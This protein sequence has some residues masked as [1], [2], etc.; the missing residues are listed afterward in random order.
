MG[1]SSLI[2]AAVVQITMSC[3][4][5]KKIENVSS[6]THPQDPFIFKNEH[7]PTQS[8]ARHFQDQSNSQSLP[9]SSLTTRNQ[10][11]ESALSHEIFHLNIK[12]ESTLN[13][14]LE[15]QTSWTNL[16]ENLDDTLSCSDKS[17]KCDTY[18]NSKNCQSKGFIRRRCIQSCG[19]CDCKQLSYL[20]LKETVSDISKKC[21]IHATPKNCRNSKFVAKRCIASCGFCK[22]KP[23]ACV[24]I[25]KKCKRHA[26][27]K[28]CK[29][30]SFI[31]KRCQKSCKLC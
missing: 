4:S 16:T 11:D 5:T 8:T 30:N 3:S 15:N 26:N 18:A 24:N 22:G 12:T 28:S 31:R 20:T 27:E 23:P 7:E 1:T 9:P 25:S 14:K 13:F 17:E 29:R 6:S 2:I 21:G 10:M 19:L